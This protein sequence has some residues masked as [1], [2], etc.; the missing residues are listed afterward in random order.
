MIKIG[1][2]P[3][4]YAAISRLVLN[5]Q[6]R[7]NGLRHRSDI[8]APYASSFRPARRLNPDLAIMSSVEEQPLDNLISLPFI[9]GLYD[10]YLRN[11]ESV[12]VDWRSYFDGMEKHGGENADGN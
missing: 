9:E 10:E 4:P 1:Q 3:S 7:E 12:P 5:P 6:K 2:F 11:P 8:D